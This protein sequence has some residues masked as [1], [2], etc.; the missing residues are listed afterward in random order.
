MDDLQLFG[1][2]IGMSERVLRVLLFDI[3]QDN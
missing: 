1:E 3:L 2:E